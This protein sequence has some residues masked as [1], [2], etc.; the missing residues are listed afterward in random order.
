MFYEYETVITIPLK[1][2]QLNIH[3]VC[4]GH[5]LQARIQELS[6]GGGGPTFRKI[7]TSKKNKRPKGPHIVHLSTMWHIFDRS[8]RADIS[9]YSSV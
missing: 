2:D 4:H 1:G 6:S 5:V 3:I 7:L 9:V 8:A